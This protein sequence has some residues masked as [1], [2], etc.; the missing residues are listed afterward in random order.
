MQLYKKFLIGILIICFLFPACSSNEANNN[1]NQ[2]VND[3]NETDSVKDTERERPVIPVGTNYGGYELRILAPENHISGISAYG[4]LYVEEEVGE[5]LNDAVFRRNM[6]VEE[7]LNFKITAIIKGVWY[8]L[9]AYAQKSIQ[10]GDDDFD[11]VYGAYQPT[12]A[13]NGC[14]VNLFNV[15]NI[16]L[17][18]PWWNQRLIEDLSYKQ[19]KLYYINGDLTFLDKYGIACLLF[20]KQLF[21]D[22]GIEYPYEQVRQG[23]WTFDEFTKL[24]KGFGTDLNGDDK[25]NEHDLWGLTGNVAEIFRFMYGSNERIMSFS[26]NNTIPTL[27]YFNERHI[28]IVSKIVDV[29]SDR[30]NILIADSGQLSHLSDGYAGGDFVNRSGRTLLISGMVGSIPDMRAVEYDFGII[31]FPKSDAAQQ[32]YYSMVSTYGWG[33]ALSIPTTNINVERTG[34]ILEVMSGYST[35]III[36]ALIDVSLKSKYVRDEESAEML[37]ILLKST[38]YDVSNE[39]AWGQ[40]VWSGLMGIYYEAVKNG[41]GKFVSSMEAQL[42]KVEADTEKWIAAF[43]ELN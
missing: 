9:A 23:R 1:N 43:E 12:L 8:E 15:N 4:D 22:Y 26:E 35:D 39:Y 13:Y 11:V 29:L 19:N 30:A 36:P 7:L 20:N 2:N 18:K 42:N 14:L 21:D 25:M 16:D 24:V 3:P 37:E 17:S 28:N 5:T 32:N 6:I 34:L 10:A 33:T 31:P 41:F 27:N 38:F 40:V